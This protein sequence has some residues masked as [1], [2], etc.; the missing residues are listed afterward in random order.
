MGAT[1]CHAPCHAWQGATPPYETLYAIWPWHATWHCGKRRAWHG[2][3]ETYVSR[4]A[5]HGTFSMK[6]EHDLA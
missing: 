3:G 5:R 2:A 4:P 1:L 6:E